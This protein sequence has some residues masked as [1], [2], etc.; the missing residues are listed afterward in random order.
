VSRLVTPLE[1]AF[2]LAGRV[3]TPRRGLVLLVL[4]A[5]VAVAATVA[6]RDTPAPNPV[7]CLEAQAKPG[8]LSC[9]LRARPLSQEPPR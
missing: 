1:A 3:L 4:L 9:E 8:G 7:A 5:A 2:E 6:R